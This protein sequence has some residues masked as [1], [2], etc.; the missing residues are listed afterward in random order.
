MSKRLTLLETALKHIDEKI[1]SLQHARQH[2]LDEQA[3]AD[4]DRAQRQRPGKPAVR[5]HS[6]AKRNAAQ[7]DSTT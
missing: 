1:A 2:L 4:R 7:V 6:G 5:L 3:T